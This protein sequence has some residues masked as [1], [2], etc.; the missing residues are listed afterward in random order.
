MPHNQCKAC[1]ATEGLVKE[2][3]SPTGYRNKCKACLR[4]EN[5][6]RRADPAYRD[7][8]ASQRRAKHHND[9]RAS[10]LTN[11][12]VRAAKQGVPFNLGIDD[13]CIPKVCPVLGI[14]LYVG[15]T[16]GPNSPTLD[17]IKPA[18][19]YVVGNIVVVSHLANRIKSDA[20][21]EQL[22]RVADYYGGL[23]A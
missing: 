11:A 21:P 23:N 20:T 10:M 17:K 2:A 5:K 7:K 16:T 8:M 19:G 4:L 1:G 12:K 22:R 3:K 14:D 13:L 6:E 18:L 15:Q 9:P